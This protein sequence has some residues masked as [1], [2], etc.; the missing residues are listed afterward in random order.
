MEDENDHLDKTNMMSLNAEDSPP[1]YNG[2]RSSHPDSATPLGGV[3]TSHHQN[4]LLIAQ[5]RYSRRQATAV[6]VLRS[7]LVVICQKICDN[8]HHMSADRLV[9]SEPYKMRGNEWRRANQILLSFHLSTHRYA[10]HTHYFA[11]RV[12]AHCAWD[13]LSMIRV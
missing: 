11:F 12:P 13:G 8:G 5:Q 7:L 2:T 6:A 3:H 10:S 4:G 9:W 1:E